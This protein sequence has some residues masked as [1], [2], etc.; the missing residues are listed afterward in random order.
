MLPRLR[1][2]FRT[3]LTSAAA[4]LALLLATAGTV[5][6]DDALEEEAEPATPLVVVTVGNIDKS[7]KDIAWM[8]E[9]IGR[10]DM[11]DVLGGLLQ[12][13]GDLKGVDRTRPFGQIIF[14]DT[15]ALPPQP[16]FI[17]FVPISNAEDAL[18]TLALSPLKPQPVQGRND[19]FEARANDTQSDAVLIRILDGYAYIAPS[20]FADAIDNMPDMPRIFEP[21]GKRYDASLS[22]RINAVPEGVRQVFV[23]FLSAQAEADLQRR[24]DEPEAAYLVRRANGVSGLE[25][26]RQVLLEGEDLT[27]GWNSQPDTKSGVFE[28]SINAKPDSS[29]AQ[30]LTD[31]GGKPSMFAALRN[32][33]RPLSVNISWAMNE[34]EKTAFN[35]L[36]DAAQTTLSDELAEIAQPE[37]PID[38]MFR[39]LH[40]TVDGGHVDFILQFAAADVQEFVLVGGVKLAGAQ[41]FGTA[42]Q[43][44]LQYA[45]MQIAEATVPAPTIT[46]NADTHQGATFHKVTPYDVREE[47]ERIYGGKPDFYVGSSSRV[48][49][50]AVGG[51]EA[52]PT[53]HDTMDALL[54]SSSAD[55]DVT[56]RMPISVTARVAPW[57]EFPDPEVN[58]AADPAADVVPTTTEVGGEGGEDA[59]RQ[60]RR[61]ERRERFR[62]RQAEMAIERREIAREAFDSTDMLRV[63]GRPTDSGFRVRVTFSEGFVRAIGLAIAR[64]Y[65]QSQL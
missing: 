62:A 15:S 31:I 42:L 44:V 19:L 26:I 40:A 50:F 38:Q 60:A 2:T 59:E 24:D 55:V 16:A 1:T 46:L 58:A 10:P 51:D 9:S 37:G 30:Y 63:E 6:A 56:Q 13:A 64:Q 27:L 22:I 29:F 18:K 52:L 12:T 57:L 14:L 33:D 23:N 5:R 49:W 41:S 21:M 28:G 47:D 25:L 3:A 8:F 4:L 34:R 36:L 45:V 35:T 43:Q 7:L 61:A 20:N 39:S 17:G 11:M 48:L 54:S 65:D 53:L 32:E